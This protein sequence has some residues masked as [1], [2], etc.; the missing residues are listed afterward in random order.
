MSAASA[1]VTPGYRALMIATPAMP[2]VI[3]AAIPE[4]ITAAARKPLP[5]NS[6]TKRRH[7]TTGSGG[8]ILVTA[9]S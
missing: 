7:S 2:P 3:W 6:A 8:G 4:P 1:G 5:R 9:P